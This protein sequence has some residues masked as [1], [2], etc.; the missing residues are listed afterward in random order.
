MTGAA[1]LEAEVAAADVVIPEG[2]RTQWTVGGSPAPG[3]PIAP[4]AQHVRHEPDD[5]TV[6]VDA[7][8]TVGRLRDT[9]AEAGQEC[10]IDARHDEATVGGVFACG[11]SGHRRLAH[12]PLRDR[13]LE[14]E[15]VLADGRR[16]RGGGPTVKNVTGFDL[17]RL[18]VGSLGT[19]GLM[20]RLTLRCTPAAPVSRWAVTAL[21]PDEVRR[22]LFRPA[23][24]AWDGSNTWCLLEG[25]E[26][27]VDAEMD[28]AG[29]EESEA[30]GWPDGSFRGRISVRP[31]ELAAVGERLPAISGLRWLGE[32]GVGTVHVAADDAGPLR[33]ARA[34]ATDAGG[35]LLGEAGD[36]LD[37]LGRPLP[38]DG[39]MRRLKDTLDPTGKMNPG[40]LGL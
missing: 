10:P 14:V 23:C 17:P 16:V 19:L 37:P 24:V 6:S 26:V 36:G 32:A 4:P 1:T 21:P 30:P 7:G 11:L 8:V 3:T 34:I 18:L 20:T 13:V 31:R 9:L 25:H 39:V 35:W 40:R 2:A 5:L 27:D 12:G 22:E 38:N 28:A 15:F 33:R 29:L